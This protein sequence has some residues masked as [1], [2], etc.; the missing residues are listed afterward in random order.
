MFPHVLSQQAIVIVVDEF[1]PQ[2]HGLDS[3]KCEHTAHL[4]CRSTDL[5]FVPAILHRYRPI[6]EQR[7]RLEVDSA[8]YWKSAAPQTENRQRPIHGATP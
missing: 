6:Q 5:K 7:P 8:P 4:A 1:S 2:R 3:G